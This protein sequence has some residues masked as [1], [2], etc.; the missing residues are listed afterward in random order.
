MRPCWST[1]VWAP[2]ASSSSRSASCLAWSLV[3]CLSAW[4]WNH[5][6]AGRC[7][8]SRWWVSRF[9]AFSASVPAWR[10]S[11][12]I[13]SSSKIFLI[14]GSRALIFRRKWS[15]TDCGTVRL[16]I[17]LPPPP[18]G[19]FLPSS[20][21]W[22]WRSTSFITARR[23]SPTRVTARPDLPARADLPTR[24]MYVVLVRGMSRLITVLTPATSSP[25]AATS[26]QRSTPTSPSLNL[27]RESSLCSWVRFPCSSPT[28]MPSKPRT[29]RNLWH[30]DL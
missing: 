12:S 22:W 20:L 30:W 2:L 25:R 6:R 10:S 17:M 16:F 5:W 3:R 26:V 29:R 8:I 21:V 7:M 13:C 4:V 15:T 28:F 23:P 18:L 11:F 19:A 27:C 1:L 14:S 9:S 24:C